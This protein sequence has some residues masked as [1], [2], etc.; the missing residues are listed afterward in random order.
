[1]CAISLV[2][3]KSHFLHVKIRLLLTR[4]FGSATL[5]SGFGADVGEGNREGQHQQHYQDQQAPRLLRVYV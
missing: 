1:M 5:S 2:L 4:V 3:K